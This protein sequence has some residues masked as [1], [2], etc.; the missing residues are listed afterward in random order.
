M[1]INTPFVAKRLSIY[2]GEGDLW[3]G[4]S[5]YMSILETL[6]KAGLSGATVTRGLAGFGQ[7]N[8]IHTNTIEGLSIDLPI[9]ITIVDISEN[10][11]KALGLIEPMLRDAL[12]T[13]E[14]IEVIKFAH[15]VRP[16]LPVDQ[17]IARIVTRNITT[18]SPDTPVRQV[19]ELLLG[20]LFKAV[21]VVD[22]R[23]Q[24]VGIITDGDLLRK[25]G[26]PIRMAIGERMDMKDWRAV[27]DKL[28][29]EKTAEQIMTA[30]AI[31][32]QETETLG[33][34]THRLLER[35]LRRLPVVNDAGQIVGMISRVDVLRAM[36]N[37]VLG[38]QV[39]DD[40][41]QERAPALKAGKTVGELMSNEVP[42]VHIDDDL[43]DVL[44]KIL[45]A[46][47][48]RVVVVDQQERA[49]GI[50][51]ESD[52]VARVSPVERPNVLQAIVARF[53]PP[54]IDVRHV[55]AGELM[56]ENVLS[57]QPE[58]TV[59]EAITLVLREGRKRLVVINKQGRPIGIVD[60]QTLLAASLGN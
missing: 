8:R 9:I 16:S 54:D 40:Q 59:M 6:H 49:V 39:T 30:P 1:N 10:I 47:I 57:A 12:V 33:I 48:K 31:T 35:G 60:R 27:L 45:A 14:D 13:L 5:L 46:D 29:N 44:Q 20:K 36:A 21:P 18:V 41:Q 2:L 42:L 17:T 53:I 34:V 32:A 52:L 55:T 19:V 3:R 50:I 15:R 22:A 56:S 37:N 11:Q 58:T 25:A 4:H 23:Q 28:S 26:M 51:T 24:V 43:I 38:Q 7:H